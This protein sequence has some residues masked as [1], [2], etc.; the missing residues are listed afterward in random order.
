MLTALCLIHTANYPADCTLEFG[1]VQSASLADA[2]FASSKTSDSGVLAEAAACVALLNPAP[3]QPGA[4]QECPPL[5]PPAS[6]P[7]LPCCLEVRASRRCLEGARPSLQLHVEKW[8]GTPRFMPPLAT[9]LNVLNGHCSPKVSESWHPTAI[10]DLACLEAGNS[11]PGGHT[12]VRGRAA[13]S[14]LGRCHKGEEAHQPP[15]ASLAAGTPAG[16][17]QQPA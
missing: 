7:S 1:N 15:R 14:R 4:L 17:R 16:G 5:P 8:T 13:E 3:R 6:C 10:Q 2:F 9:R 12:D 11:R